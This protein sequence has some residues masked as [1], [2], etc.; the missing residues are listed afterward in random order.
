MKQISS[1]KQVKENNVSLIRR[2]IRTCDPFTKN[3]VAQ[4][5]GLSIATCNTLLNSMAASG[6]ILSSGNLGNS[7]GRPAK[8]YIYN[9]N[10]SHICC[11]F[12]Y[13]AREQSFLHYA[14]YDLLGTLLEEQDLTFA[15]ID[16][17]AM[18]DTVSL[19]LEKDSVISTFSIGIPGYV[20]SEF[21]HS[22]TMKDLA[23]CDLLGQLKAHFSCTFHM[24]NNMNAIA[25]GLYSAR[26]AEYETRNI[27]GVTV[28][29]YFEG[30]D[31][32]SGIIIKGKIHTGETG[33]AGESAFLPYEDHTIGQLIQKGE[34]ELL[35]NLTV[36]IS[37]YAAILNPSIIAVTGERINE[38]MCE[39]ASKECLKYIPYQHMPHVQ[40]IRNYNYYY[41]KGLF[42]LMLDNE[43]Y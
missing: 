16:Y 5:T 39:T 4:T 34:A 37:S 21:I 27:S 32:G 36:T 43:L 14:I 13:S 41:L 40:Y 23:G 29:S 6:E 2:I 19:L 42:D 25:Y 26:K 3:S 20:D 9:R 30:G 18:E 33:F 31:S 24:E 11:L 35:R 38:A 8:S 10:Y 7:V 12:P 22:S 1:V 17:Q 28:I 15:R